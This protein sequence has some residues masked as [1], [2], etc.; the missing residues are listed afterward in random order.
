M[1]IAHV[2]LAFAVVV[3]G[4]LAGCRTN[5]LYIYANDTMTMQVVDA[6]LPGVRPLV[7]SMRGDPNDASS[8]AFDVV[9]D[10]VAANVQ[11]KLEDFAPVQRVSPKVT[12]RVAEGVP[13]YLRN[14]TVGDS[15]PKARLEISVRN[16]GVDT[17][18][19]DV[20]A[21]MQVSARMV[22]FAVGSTI[23]E[24]TEYV[25]VPVRTVPGLIA[26]GPGGELVSLS[27]L[28]GFSDEQWRSILDQ[29]VTSASDA[30]LTRMRN[31]TVAH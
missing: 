1:K 11:Q 31:D 19:P 29:L 4:S 10:V 20:S 17:T 21:F 16:Y 27:V 18:G 26:I 2:V 23:W 13:T 8:V 14:T 25:R 3:V 28:A 5:Q 9:E 7:G 12:T 24:T 6:P 15:D 30:V 22:H